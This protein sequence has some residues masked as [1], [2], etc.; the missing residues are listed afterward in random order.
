MNAKSPAS[1][2]KYSK[3]FKVTQNSRINVF[4]SQ[5]LFNTKHRIGFSHNKSNA[6]RTHEQN[7]QYRL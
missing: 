1:V 2:D 7:D 4:R 6:H 3:L 5:V